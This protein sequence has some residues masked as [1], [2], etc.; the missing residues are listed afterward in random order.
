MT[1]SAASPSYVVALVPA[2]LTSRRIPGKN[3]IQ[4]A[5]QELYA[6][7]V[8]AGL[9]ASG[10]DEVFVS[11]ESPELLDAA[12]RYGAQPILRPMELAGPEVTNQ[13]VIE[14]ALAHIE[15]L[16]GR[17][18]DLLALLQPTHPFRFPPD[19]SAAVQIM[20]QDPEADSLFALRRMDDLTGTLR[21]GHF[22]PD[23]PVPRNRSAEPER[24]MNTGSFYILRPSHTI[25]RGSFFGSAIRG[26]ALS[27]PDMEIDIDFPEQLAMAHCMAGYFHADLK[28]Y[29]LM[30]SGVE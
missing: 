3:R 8:R 10:V 7:S 13:K 19:I 28:S 29:G 30:D 15:G 25:D 18:P 2:K 6:Y 24:Y 16:R 5:G 26:Y 27:R 4:I 1:F 23:M 14:D 20:A 12:A 17:R 9:A 22:H 11:S 21:A